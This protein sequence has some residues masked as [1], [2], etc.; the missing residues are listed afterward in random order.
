MW[1][2]STQMYWDVSGRA[3]RL[4]YDSGLV[5]SDDDAGYENRE[6]VVRYGD[7]RSR[8]KKARGCSGPN[9]PRLALCALRDKVRTK[10]RPRRCPTSPGQ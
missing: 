4:A 7:P 3:G 5:A 10:D 9:E 2:A 6:S 8:D 1:V